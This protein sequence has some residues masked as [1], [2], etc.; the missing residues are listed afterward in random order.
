MQ[1]RSATQEHVMALACRPSLLLILTLGA[2]ASSVSAD[3]NVR[4]GAECRVHVPI[5]FGHRGASGALP[6]H[7]ARA[8]EL[9]IDLGA[10]FI[11]P[12]LVSTKDGHLVVRHENNIKDTTDVAQHPEFADRQVTKLVEGVEETGW[13]TEDFTLAELKT[14]RAV[15][16]LAELRPGNTASD[17]LHAL[18]TLDEVIAI[19][20]RRGVG[21]FPE[22]KKPTWFREIGLPMEETLVASMHAHGYVKASDPAFLQSF[23]P[24]SL[25]RL[26]KLTALRLVQAVNTPEVV[27][28]AF[29]Q[30]GDPRTYGDLL[31]PEG[32]QYVAGYA[33][34]IGPEKNLLIPRADDGSLQAPTHLLDDAHHAGLEVYAYTF[35]RENA[36]LP[37]DFRLGDPE[38]PFYD[39]ATGDIAAEYRRFY[40]LGVD[41]VWSDNPDTAVAVRRTVFPPLGPSDPAHPRR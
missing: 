32:L 17:G 11:E 31:T 23:D 7:T 29:T 6:E 39:Q 3:D 16:R 2:A 20:Q 10:D 22:L 24:A 37:L 40:E 41:G 25:Q 15:E 33:A 13:F 12:D 35:R 30:S 5:V 18:L 4:P 9:A 1:R 19:A 34:A 14:L 28:Y 8:F 27:P 36:F 26:S 38:S 21:I